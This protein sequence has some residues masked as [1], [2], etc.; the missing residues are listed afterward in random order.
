[1]GSNNFEKYEV[2]EIMRSDIH[3]ADYN[4]RMIDKEA[5]KRLREN[6][7]GVGL[8]EPVV[9]NRVTGRLV[10]GHQRVKILDGLHKGTDYK[11]TVAAVEMD[12]KTEKE[13][14]IFMNNPEAQGEFDFS[15]LGDMLKSGID[16]MAA[17]FDPAEVHQMFGNGI[18]NDTPEDI[19]KIADHVRELEE[20]VERVKN[21][22]QDKNNQDFYLVVVFRS[23]EDRKAF[24]DKY[25]IEDNMYVSSD[26]IEDL[27]DPNREVQES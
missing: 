5:V 25:G 11:L 1:M 19:K 13:Q 20:T 22:S 27:I 24:T 2:V 7:K 8:V 18:M 10:S 9:W 26:K 14:N 4:P 21:Q 17:G 23:Y 15:K 12:E 3:F 6:I 16:A